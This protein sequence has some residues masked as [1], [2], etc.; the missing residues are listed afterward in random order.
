M[1]N[2]CQWSRTII[3]SSA[4]WNQLYYK[5]AKCDLVL[6]PVMMEQINTCCFFYQSNQLQLHSC[7]KCKSS[8]SLIQSAALCLRTSAKNKTKTK[9]HDVINVSKIS[10]FFNSFH[11]FLWDDWSSESELTGLIILPYCFSSGLK[12][13]SGYFRDP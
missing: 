10:C 7:L 11:L 4:D 5:R 2:N 13:L 1:T 8:K 12:K 6:F 3:A 9:Q